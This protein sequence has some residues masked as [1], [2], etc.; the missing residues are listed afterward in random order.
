MK[1][2]DV[3]RA[4]FTTEE[5]RELDRIVSWYGA[6]AVFETPERTYRGRDEIR[7]FYSSAA[8]LYPRLNVTIGRCLDEGGAAA[9]EW[10][11]VLTS[12]DGVA[13]R[14][15]GVNLADVQDDLIIS[16]RAYYAPEP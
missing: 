13:T 11:A 5:G 2:S 9:V 7:E 4:Y 14:M 8:A 1:P 16:A 12:A 3:L 15:R 10:R 6:D